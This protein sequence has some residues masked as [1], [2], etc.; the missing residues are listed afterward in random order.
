M[1]WIGL[2]FLVPLGLFGAA[3]W[4]CLSL[5]R[6]R[7]ERSLA[8]YLFHGIRF[9][10]PDWFAPEARPIQ[11]RFLLLFGLFLLSIVAAAALAIVLAA[12]A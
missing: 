12:P 6:Y 10:D 11:R 3:L 1:N 8:P 2:I 7:R 9:F 4:C 5:L